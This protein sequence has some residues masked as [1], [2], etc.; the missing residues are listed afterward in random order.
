MNENF[1]AKLSCVNYE[2]AEEWGAWHLVSNYSTA[3][4]LHDKICGVNSLNL[5]IV[6]AGSP[7]PS[8]EFVAEQVLLSW[9]ESSEL[10]AKI[11]RKNG[12]YG[13]KCLVSDTTGCET[14]NTL[15]D[16]NPAKSFELI[17]ESL[18]KI[19]DYEFQEDTVRN[20]IV[21]MYGNSIDVVKPSVRGYISIDY[22][23][24][25]FSLGLREQ[26]IE[27]LL[28]ITPGDLHQAAV[29]LYENSR[30][31]RGCIIT[32]DES[33]ISGNVFWNWRLY[34]DYSGEAL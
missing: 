2:D 8:K 6:F 17:E 25:G 11:R 12:A 32:G 18:K 31:L 27:N 7:Y 14:I 19:M 20:L 15:R 24:S 1:T 30:L 16:P 21:K 9:L 5:Q 3:A 34:K 13:I 29:W 28:K 22:C 4:Q 33:Q 26:R 10:F 23:L